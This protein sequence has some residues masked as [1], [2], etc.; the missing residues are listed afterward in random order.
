MNIIEKI[1]SYILGGVVLGGVIICFALLCSR[2]LNIQN[3]DNYFMNDNYYII[4]EDEYI[5]KKDINLCGRIYH[6]GVSIDSGFYNEC[7]SK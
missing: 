3:L 4:N 2:F 7:M 6:T 5:L 1:L